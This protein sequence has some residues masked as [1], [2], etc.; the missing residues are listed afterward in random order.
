MLT[1][2]ASWFPWGLQGWF[3]LLALPASVAQQYFP[4]LKSALPAVQT[5]SLIGSALAS[6]VALL[7]LAGAG[8]YLTGAA[9]ALFSQRPR[10]QPPAT[11]PYVVITKPLCFGLS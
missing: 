4:L 3:S 1:F 10:L 11:N 7:E 5:T 2:H 6:V 8:S 9:S